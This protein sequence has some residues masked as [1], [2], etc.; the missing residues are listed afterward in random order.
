MCA[1]GISDAFTLSLFTAA[2]Q[3]NKDVLNLS[4]NMHPNS[5]ILT[6]FRPGFVLVFCNRGGGDPR[7]F[8]ENMTM[9]VD[10]NE[11]STSENVSF[12]VSIM[13]L[14]RRMT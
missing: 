3:L 4:V 9:T 1:T 10:H 13:R 7:N 6:L 11:T 2:F 5:D 12:E 14:W 8:A